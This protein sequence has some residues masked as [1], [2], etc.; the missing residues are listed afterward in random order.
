MAIKLHSCPLVLQQYIKI[1]NIA[2]KINNPLTQKN[3]A[4]TI[5]ASAPINS[6][7]CNVSLNLAIEFG[8]D[9]CSHEV[10]KVINIGHLYEQIVSGSGGLAV[11][12]KNLRKMLSVDQKLYDK[13]KVKLPYFC[14]GRFHGNKR[15]T[16]NF[17]S[18]HIL[19]MDLDD[20]PEGQ[21]EILKRQLAQDPRIL[22]MF[23]SPSG[24]GLKIVFVLEQAIFDANL[25]T[26]FYRAFTGK[27]AA[28][29]S[30]EDYT[31]FKTCDAARVCFL[32]HDE[33]AIFNQEA[34]ALKIDSYLDQDSDLFSALTPLSKPE[35]NKGETMPISTRAKTD[36]SAEQMEQMLK[37]LNPNSKSKPVAPVIVPE[38]LFEAEAGLRTMAHENGF[39]LREVRDIQYGKTFVLFRGAQYAEINVFYG[40]KNGFSVVKTT[41]KGSNPQLAELCV[42]MLNC[43]LY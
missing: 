29:Y 15:D 24:A 16:G 25:Y 43:L 14:A 9:L 21:P 5:T 6:V 42:Q 30:L 1:P 4:T 41:K 7:V 39:E 35:P 34:Q 11:L 23:V 10:M 38:P 31:D 28:Q 40:K 13:Q 8:T 2:G 20:L 3:T 33:N 37:I 17:I 27:F 12:Q 18:G 32:A 26:R 19:V 22:L 36:I